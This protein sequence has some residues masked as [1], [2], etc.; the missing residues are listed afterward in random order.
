[1]GYGESIPLVRGVG[2]REV[3]TFKYRERGVMP[4]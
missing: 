3:V 1:M 4:L 2:Y